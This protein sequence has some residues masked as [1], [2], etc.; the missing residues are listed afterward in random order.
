[1]LVE[2]KA[3]VDFFLR[4]LMFDQSECL[5]EES[6]LY[7]AYNSPASSGIDDYNVAAEVEM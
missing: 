6:D 7:T 3:I 5:S 1:M 2:K 4:H